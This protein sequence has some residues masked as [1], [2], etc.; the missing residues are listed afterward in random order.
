MQEKLKGSLGDFML[1]FVA[2]IWGFGFVAVK[3]GLDNGMGSFYLLFLRFIVATVAL[4]PYII[5]RIR[6]IT[7]NSWKRGSLL[8]ILL[9]L[10]FAFQT[11]GLT[12]TTTSKNAFIT[13][14]NVVIVPF[15]AYFFSKKKVD[16][17]SQ[18]A[19]LLCLIGIGMLTLN[20][21]MSINV[22]DFLTLICAF[23]FAAQIVL[24]AI[25]THDEDALTL[26]W[27]EM[28]IGA[29]LSL[30]FA[31]AFQERFVINLSSSLAILYLGLFSSLLAFFLQAI[32]L[33]HAPATRAAILLS[34]E[35]L[36]GAIF[37]VLFFKD[38]LG[39]QAILG[40]ILIFCAIIISETK[41]S[42][43]IKERSSESI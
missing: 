21:Q 14:A 43:L 24:T 16:I 25:I 38:K 33:R 32:G 8:G 42:F 40:C 23:M 19:A 31:L 34:T 30:I 39:P 4:L 10:G 17:F 7:M 20:D 13:G 35:S 29:I 37:A 22:G 27:I 3:I 18:I 26:V 15:L 28:L 5:K 2:I 1:L 6:K 11:I 41:L 36:F 12:Y 9:F